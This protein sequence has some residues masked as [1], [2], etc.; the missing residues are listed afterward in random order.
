MHFLGS[1]SSSSSLNDCT[2]P[3]VHHMSRNAH[4]LRTI[5][6]CVCDTGT[7]H[8][9]QGAQ[10]S[11]LELEPRR[12]V[13]VGGARGGAQLTQVVRRLARLGVRLR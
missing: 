4:T 3:N 11:S 5:F 2:T 1:S 12:G 7:G 9:A 6:K 10:V 8:K 13:V